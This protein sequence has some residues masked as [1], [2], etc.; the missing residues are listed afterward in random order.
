MSFFRWIGIPFLVGE[1]GWAGTSRP[2]RDGWESVGTGEGGHADC[3]LN[4]RW[5]NRLKSVVHR[6]VMGYGSSHRHAAILLRAAVDSGP[7]SR[8]SIRHK[9]SICFVGSGRFVAQVVVK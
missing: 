9:S 6:A 2:P 7:G 5:D 4:M 3:H 1:R 8:T